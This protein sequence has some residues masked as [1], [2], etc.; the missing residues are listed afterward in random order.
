M[1]RRAVIIGAFVA[2]NVALPLSYYTC[3]DDPYDER[4]A[5]RMFSSTR[6]ARCQV[7][8]ASAG[9]AVPLNRV[10]HVAWIKT[11]RRGRQN[12][13]E[14]MGQHLCEHPDYGAPVTLT[15]SCE[16]VDGSVDEIWNGTEDL[17]Q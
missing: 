10:F 2:L 8:F 9:R 17:C 12:V 16:G 1:S 11:A 15:M 7:A 13:V 6:M 5:W 14:A 4:F 3:E